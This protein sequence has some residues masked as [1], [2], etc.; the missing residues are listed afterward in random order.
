M[1]SLFHKISFAL[2]YRY[3]GRFS[4]KIRKLWYSMLG[5]KIGKLTSLP[6]LY[7][8]WPHQ[9][10][11]GDNC[12]LEHNI[13]FKYDGIWQPGPSI[14]IADDV[15]IGSGCEFNINQKITIGKDALIASGCR[16][17]DHNH[18][19]ETHELM[20]KQQSKG[21]EIK[22]GR[23]VWL[24]CN[25]VVLKGVHINDGAIIAAGAV[26]TKNVPSK[27]IWAGIPARKIGTR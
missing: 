17:I 8:T 24:G 3:Y 2:R 21:F 14:C 16:F 7:V 12:W 1:T 4:G 23:D 25:V 22:I 15:F 20:R 10:S 9:V 26:V 27:E 18:G 6:K 5:M 11:I 19:T 13:Y